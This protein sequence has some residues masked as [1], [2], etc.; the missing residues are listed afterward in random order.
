[1]GYNKELTQALGDRKKD[2]IEKS[3]KNEMKRRKI[4]DVDIDYTLTEI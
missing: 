4:A 2:T 1:M 3:V